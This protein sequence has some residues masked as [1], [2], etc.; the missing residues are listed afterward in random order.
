MSLQPIRPT[1]RRAIVSPIWAEFFADTSIPAAVRDGRTVYLTGHTGEDDDLTFSPDPEHQIRRTFLNI[2]QTLAEAGT[3]WSDVVEIASYHVGLRSQADALLTVA[4]EF[5]AE[6]MPAWTAV[7]VT[8]LW[9][10]GSVVEMSCVAVIG[11]PTA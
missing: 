11:G 10:E 1:S 3:D 5:L 7:G 2:A 6:P 8:E 9:D 4:R